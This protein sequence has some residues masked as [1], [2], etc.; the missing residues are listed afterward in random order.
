MIDSVCVRPET[1]KVQ[2]YWWYIAQAHVSSLI[3]DFLDTLGPR[4]TV[5]YFKTL[6]LLPPLK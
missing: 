5:R 6:Q 4:G 2:W 1:P 3:S